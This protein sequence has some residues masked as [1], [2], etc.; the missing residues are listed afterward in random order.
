MKVLRNLLIV[1]VVLAVIAFLIPAD[2]RDGYWGYLCGRGL[3]MTGDTGGASSSYKG[4]YEAMPDN[5]VFAAAYA[6]SQNDLG[7]SLKKDDHFNTAKDVATR[8]ID[9]HEDDERVFLMYIELARSEWGRNRKPTAKIA[10]DK[11]VDLMPTDYT[12]LVYQGII[13][14]DYQP[15]HM[16]QV[17]T[18]IPIFEQAIKVRNS[19]KTYWAEFELAK[20][21]WLVKDETR[22]LN[23]LDQALSQFPPRWLRLEA[24]RLKHEIQSSGRSE[25]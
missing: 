6:R 8:W 24:E 9:A 23:E 19:T 13:Y 14:R 21:W 3:E 15:G 17:R 25:Q 4:A 11:A 18:S 5:V 12:A 20:A 7:E 2:I 16:D 22:A 10:I 1:L